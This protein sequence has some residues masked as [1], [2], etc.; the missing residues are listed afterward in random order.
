MTRLLPI[1]PGPRMPFITR[2]GRRRGADRARGAHVVRA[3]GLGAAGEVVALDRALEALALGGAGDLDLS[4][5]P[6]T[7]RPSRSRRPCS[8]PASSRNSTRCFIG[9]A[10]AFLR[11]PSSGL[12][13]VLLLRRAER[14]LDGLVAVALERADRGDRAG[15]GLEHGDALDAAVLQEELGH[16][17]LLGEDRG[18]VRPRGWIS[19]STPAGRWSRRWS[20]STVFGVGWWMSMSRL[21]VR[22]SKCSLRVLVLERG[23]DHGSRRSSPSAA[24]PGPDTVAPVRVA[25]STISL[26]AVSMADV[27]VGLEADADL[28]LGRCHVDLSLRTWVGAAPREPPPGPSAWSSRSAYWMTSVTTPEPTVR[29]PSRMAKRRPA[30]MAIGWISSISIWTLSPGH[31][32]LDA[33][34]QVRDAGHVRR[35]E[36]ELRAVAGEERR[37]AAALLL[38]EDVHLGLELGVRRDRP[39]LAE[40]LAALDL[41]ALGAAQQAADVVAGLALVE[42]LAEHLDAGDD[43]GG[44]VVDA[45]DLDVVAGVDDALLDAAGRDGAAA[46]DREDVLDRHQERACRASRSGSGM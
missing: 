9:G 30:S 25:V 36:V 27:V 1:W 14:E 46:G 21:C 44:R 37:V 31:D 35:A 41:L 33:L 45:D 39:G 8:S 12:G 16:P 26:A 38:L 19:M 29:P 10:S 40:H 28:V 2:D 7:P 17:E 43:R 22:I 18:H 42:D 34:G 6:R 4:G 20:E 11:W 5:R 32:H 3:V 23:P 13:E 15:A 24:A